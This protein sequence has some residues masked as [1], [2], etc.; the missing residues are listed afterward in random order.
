MNKPEQ[1]A[2][3]RDAIAIGRALNLGQNEMAAAILEANEDH[4]KLFAAVMDAWIGYLRYNEK[5][6]DAYF[7]AVQQRFIAAEAEDELPGIA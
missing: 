4:D 5:N 3:F 7:A 6:V 1:L 2:N